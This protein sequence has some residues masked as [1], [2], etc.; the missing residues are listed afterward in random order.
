MIIKKNSQ[1]NKLTDYVFYT[2]TTVLPTSGPKIT[3]DQNEYTVGDEIQANCT[4]DRS[5]LDIIL[6]FTIN[7]EPVCIIMVWF[8]F[9]VAGKF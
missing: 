3:T 2:C 5:N 7:G 9:F 4:S 8:F 6:N 1:F